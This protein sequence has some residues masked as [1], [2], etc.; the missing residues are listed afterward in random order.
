MN[1]E[2]LR[3]Q[4]DLHLTSAAA[5]A[6]QQALDAADKAPHLSGEANRT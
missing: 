4:A 5:R 3:L 2:S 1:A 6:L